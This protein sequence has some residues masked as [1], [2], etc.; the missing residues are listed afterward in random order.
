[1]LNAGGGGSDSDDTSTPPESNSPPVAVDDSASTWP[2][3]AIEIDVLSNDSDA[4]GDSLDITEVT[5][6]EHGFVTINSSGTDSLTYE[7]ASPFVGVDTFTY[8]IDDGN[9]ES[10]SATVAVNV[11]DAPTLIITLP[12]EGATVDGPE[13]TITFEVNGCNVSTPSAD[14][15][16]CHV[17][18]YLDDAEYRD[19]DG[20]G[21]GH[22]N[23]SPFTISP[24]SDGEH[25]FMLYLI[26][27][28]GSDAPFDPLISDTVTF[29][30]TSDD[31]TGTSGDDTGTSGDDTG[32]SGDDTGTSGDDT[33]T[34]D[35]P[36]PD[37]EPLSCSGSFSGDEGPECCDTLGEPF[38]SPTRSDCVEGEWTCSTG[39]VCTCGGE[40]AEYECLD[41][42]GGSL[43]ELPFC[44]FGDHFECSTEAPVASDTCVEDI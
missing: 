22:Y 42:C 14:P 24:V 29:T 3:V 43:I 27:N 41:A 38:S 23:S 39:E 26:A 9:G 10:D 15:G 28:D 40:T 36:V 34:S 19:A 17:H 32:S 1:M 11:T 30:V 16:G 7:P 20:T 25:S 4:D 33:G 12:E 6:P 5:Q 37:P 31:D 13:I 35:E 21:F 44:V 8:T 18:K 2:G